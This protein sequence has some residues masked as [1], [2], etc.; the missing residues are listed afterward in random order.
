M[1]KQR[2]QY[3]QPPRL[4]IAGMVAGL[5]SLALIAIAFAVS[6]VQ[7]QAA[8][9]AY[10]GGESTWSRSQLSAVIKLDR[11]ARSGDPLDLEQA[12]SWLAVPL[13]DREARLAMDGAS[14]DMEVARAGLIRGGNHPDDVGRM[15]WLVRYL[16]DIDEFRK[17][18]VA[19]KNTDS[20]LLE[21]REIGDA[22]AKEWSAAQPDLAKIALLRRQVAATNDKLQLLS[23]QFR[24]AMGDAARWVANALSV[25][26]AVFL[27]FLAFV[28]WQISARLTRS[29]RH[30]AQNFRAIFEQ[31]AVGI[32]QINSEGRVL[33][34]NG[35]LS[36][37][38][39]YSKSQLF[40]MRYEDLLH[41]EDRESG[42]L[43]QQEVRSG[44]SDNYTF[45]QRLINSGG[46]SLWARLT[47]S[48]GHF[49]K[50]RTTNYIVVLEDISES[51][52]MSKELSYQAN[53]DELTG[54]INRR[55]FERHLETVLSQA[56]TE[57]SSHA[58]CFLDLDQFKVVNDTS[59]HLSGDELLRQVAAVARYSLRESDVL[60]RLGGDEFGIILRNLTPDAAAGI[61]E[62]L[63][64]ALEDMTFTWEG[65]SHSVGCSIGVVPITA[66]DADISTLMRAVDIA[67]YVAKSQGRNRTYLSVADDI[68]ISE[69]HTEME[70]VNRI[71]M[72]LQENRFF[73]EAQ[74]I[75]PSVTGGSGLRYEV[76]IRL[77]NEDGGTAPPGA[78]LPAAERFGIAHKID[79]WVIDE[80]FS[81]LVAHTMHLDELDACHINLSGR[82]FDQ[83][84][85]AEFVIERL[86]YYGLSG[87][88][89]CFE[90]TET[91]AMHNLADVQNFMARLRDSKCTF[92][93]DDF[94]TGLS[95]FSY[96]RRL[97]VDYL[98]IDGVFVRDIVTDQTDLAMVRAINDI[99]QTLKK[100]TIAEFVENDE[101]LELL[102]EM[103]VDYVQ[104]Y[105]LH[106]PCL[107]QDFLTGIIGSS[108]G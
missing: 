19:W 32:A 40:A 80:A 31:A 14:A 103:G 101:T 7:I 45:Q 72:A 48:V 87:S 23:L 12:R 21:L 73:L 6:I 75:A 11:Y 25:A 60:A 20:G 10:M 77:R 44:T 108:R 2:S 3:R 76:L 69:E 27:P 95:S 97:P 98:K 29:V 4:K 58:L 50:N 65:R 99:G 49:Q 53:H 102:K 28:A 33:D 89:I 1:T 81:Q 18:I 71:Q 30:S 104:G 93:L 5:F 39:G 47:V 38:L 46:E 106:R 15:I 8:V 96:L 79:R 63:R 74:L 78:F 16:S 62:K 41:L 26:S 55:A 85:F 83:P 56:H 57:Q 9:A 105:G 59:G 51:Y 88:K 37:I 52:R 70:W 22:L 36:K 66:G 24:E 90:L 34:V 17:A 94:G 61:A 91:A 92:A 82:S 42:R 35:T 107:F 86:Q 54:L 68:Q 67:C 43:Q 64:A 84:D 100:K 13:A